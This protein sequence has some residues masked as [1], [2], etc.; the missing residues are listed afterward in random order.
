[1]RNLSAFKPKIPAVL[2]RIDQDWFAVHILERS[3]TF[4]LEQPAVLIV[5]LQVRSG[6]N[7][8]TLSMIT[9]GDD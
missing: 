3:A 4:L 5:Y 9:V 8:S 2:R 1:V 7:R 6:H